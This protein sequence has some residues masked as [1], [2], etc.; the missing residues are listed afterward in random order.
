[1]LRFFPD[2][3]PQKKFFSPTHGYTNWDFLNNDYQ[4]EVY[5][6]SF[7]LKLL[8]SPNFLSNSPFIVFGDGTEPLLI[9]LEE[10]IVKSQAEKLLKDIR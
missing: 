5:Y 7:S 10:F 8:W 3:F 4:A 2:K 6:K 9:L 1:M